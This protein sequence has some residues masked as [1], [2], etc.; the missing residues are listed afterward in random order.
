MLVQKKTLK[1]IDNNNKINNNNKLSNSSK[2]NKHNKIFLILK[3]QRKQLRRSDS[4]GTRTF[5]HSLVILLRAFSSVYSLLAASAMSWNCSKNSSRCRSISCS[6]VVS[7]FGVMSLPTISLIFSQWRGRM[8]G[9]ARVCSM[10]MSFLNSSIW[11][12]VCGVVGCI[13]GG[14]H[15]WCVAWVD[16]M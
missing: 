3:H 2:I 8:L 9:L 10:G 6:S 14:V 5:S 4:K 16:R 7:S 12:L 1:K 13:V 11:C 15:A